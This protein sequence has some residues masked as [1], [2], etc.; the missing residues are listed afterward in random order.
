MALYTS[1]VFDP[2]SSTLIGWYVINSAGQR[3]PVLSSDF[4][5]LSAVLSGFD[6]QYIV[7]AYYTQEAKPR[8][9]S[10]WLLAAPVRYLGGI[11]DQPRWKVIETTTH[12][13]GLEVYGYGNRYFD[14]EHHADTWDEAQS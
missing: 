1:I 12:G 6:I 11:G 9:P 14:R 3:E 10:A 7:R 8:Q 5:D 2:Y 13:D 4:R